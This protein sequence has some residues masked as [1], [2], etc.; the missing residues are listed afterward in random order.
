[1]RFIVTGLT[2]NFLGDGLASAVRFVDGLAGTPP[3]PF[4][5]TGF[6]ASTFFASGFL[7]AG[8][9]EL[10]SFGFAVGFIFDFL[11]IFASAVFLAAGDFEAAAA[12]FPIGLAVDGGAVFVECPVLADPTSFDGFATL[13]FACE[14]VSRFFVFDDNASKA[15]VRAD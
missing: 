4:L 12:D 13:A 15:A 14:V 2:G 9:P 10:L 11:S 8:F 7:T 3:A 1:M 6:L 5:L